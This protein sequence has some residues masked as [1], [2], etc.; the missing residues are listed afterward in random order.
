[1]WRQA[2]KFAEKA[3]KKIMNTGTADFGAVK[4]NFIPN[5]TLLPVLGSIL[6]LHERMPEDASF[7]KLLSRWYWS[8]VL[9]EDYSGSSDSVMA[10]DFREWRKWIETDQSESHIERLKQVSKQFVEEIDFTAVGRGSSRYN[11]VICMLALLGAQDFYES[12]AVGNMDYSGERID[13]HHI[14]PTGAAGEFSTETSK[15]FSKLKD[16]IL[17]RTLLLDQT[18]QKIRKKKPSGYISEMI[19]RHGDE[20]KVIMIFASHL[21][22]PQAYDYMKKDNFDGFVLEREK[23]IKQHISSK[24]A[25][26]CI[27][28]IK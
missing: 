9:S 27:Q 28:E 21:I 15:R 2:G 19:R 7:R 25:L 11:A 12:Q 5:T 14:F 24:L 6:W 26:T 17:N 22:S 3:R 8:A 20:Q 13:D 10:K 1:M 4:A 23:T 18:N 16:C